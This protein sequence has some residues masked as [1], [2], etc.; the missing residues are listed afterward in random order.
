MERNLRKTRSGKVVSNKMDKTIVVAIE[1]NVKHPLIGKIVKRTYKL[2]AHDENNECQI[3]DIV[4]VMETRPIS[5]DKRWRLV[6]IVEKA[7]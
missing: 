3:G 7:K 6:E 1:D 2:K 4:K 5:K